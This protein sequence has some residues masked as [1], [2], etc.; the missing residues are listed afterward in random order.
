[1]VIKGNKYKVDLNSQEIIC[2]NTTIWTYL[3]DSKEVQINTYEPDA[4]TI[5]PDQIFNIY[6][7]DFLFSFNSETTVNGVVTEVIDL[8]PTDKNKP[9][10]KVRLNI[11]KNDNAINSAV[12]MF[13]DGKKYTFE[14]QKLVPDL[15]LNDS[16][17]SFDP[18]QYPGIN[19]EDLR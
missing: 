3:K 8:T 4:S 10:F 14:I 18:K 6:Q 9:Y 17:F 15:V 13:K 7:K 2:D 12:F 19:V 1:M 5:S 11:G 16:F